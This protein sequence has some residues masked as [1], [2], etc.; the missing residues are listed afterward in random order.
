MAGS[1][2]TMQSI[3]DTI[4]IKLYEKLNDLFG[5]GSQ[6]FCMEYPP[7]SLNARDYAYTIED[8]TGVLFK[9]QT[10]AES[11]FN[12][13][14]NIVDLAPI[15]QGSTGERVSNLYKSVLNNY[16]PRLHY[17]TRLASE[18][19]KLKS[20]L[21]EPIKGKVLDYD[22]ETQTFTQQDFEG[23]RMEYSARLYRTYLYKRQ[24]YN[25]LINE[26]KNKVKR[27][28]N[29]RQA[30]IEFSDWLS[31]VAATEEEILSTFYNDAVVRGNLHEVNSAISFLDI[32]SL[33]QRLNEIKRDIR[34]NVKR[35]VIGG[36]DVYPV[37]LSPS[38]WFESLTQSPAPIDVI[39]NASYRQNLIQSKSNELNNA[40]QQLSSLQN[41]HV[42][43]DSLSSLEQE[44]KDLNKAIDDAYVAVR[45]NFQERLVTAVQF[46]QEALTKTA[47]F[48]LAV[49]SGGLTAALKSKVM[50]LAKKKARTTN[51]DEISHIEKIASQTEG[52]LKSFVK[53][54]RARQESVELHSKLALAKSSD[55]DAQIKMLKH[56]IAELTEDLN[57]LESEDALYPS[58]LEQLKNDIYFTASLKFTPDSTD[59]IK[60]EIDELRK[61]ETSETSDSNVAVRKEISGIN[62]KT[63]AEIKAQG[64]LFLKEST[65]KPLSDFINE[66]DFLKGI[67]DNLNSDEFYGKFTKANN[68][69]KCTK[70]DFKQFVNT[71]VKRY[72]DRSK[73]PGD[74]I[75]NDIPCFKLLDTNTVS[76]ENVS[77]IVES[78]KG[79]Q[80]TV[81]LNKI[82]TDYKSKIS[83]LEKD[84]EN[85]KEKER[86]IT[87]KVVA[88]A[89]RLGLGKPSEELHDYYQTIVVE[90]EQSEHSSTTS[91]S[92][93]ASSSGKSHDYFFSSGS[94]SSSRS[95]AD[96][97]AISESKSLK[98]TVKL[99]ATKV[100]IER[101]GWF[102][103]DILRLTEG[104]FHVDPNLK[105]ATGDEL[106]NFQEHGKVTSTGKFTHYPM[107]FIIVKDVEISKSASEAFS[108]SKQNSSSS[109]SSSRRDGWFSSSHSESSQ[110]SRH[111]EGE[112]ADKRFFETISLPS[113][114]ILGWFQQVVPKDESLEYA[115]TEEKKEEFSQTINEFLKS[116]VF[117]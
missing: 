67:K 74:E 6:A 52:A 64:D 82:L 60:A 62:K 44:I 17:A 45:K 90:F 93:A 108:T 11:E 21:L 5:Q 110:Q 35:S 84:K 61:L 107:S 49:H 24:G 92:S 55:Y 79:D 88:L 1:T 19:G 111:E 29:V 105:S 116:I 63:V 50:D 3:E 9:P 94:S 36:G 25:R 8:N 109:S 89:K 77:E 103:V 78:L 2:L 14:D 57:A 98:V 99:R 101:G 27:D 95:N 4:I 18:K 81:E 117:K 80:N 32:P 33:G 20:W 34:S 100:T 75:K 114:A 59:A 106:S 91:Q 38:N 112:A 68:G 53:L 97:S 43:Q 31:T 12:L 73:I 46:A 76:E 115:K 104:M 56:Q 22:K 102:G 86:E 85:E 41:I 72:D 37:N 23:T 13:T 39:T 87:S 16:I 40:R 10:V 58:S 28:E 65:K 30:G 7:R 83:E 51:D 48:G 69:F 26:E 42:S 113:P 96:T 66:K 15:V 70:D 47:E 54:D 71:I